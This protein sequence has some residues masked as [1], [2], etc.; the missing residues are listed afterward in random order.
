MRL[1]VASHDFYPDPGSGGTGRYVYETTRRLADRGHDVTVITR[2]RG[3]C[4]RRETVAGVRVRRYDLTIADRWGPGVLADLPGAAGAVSTFLDDADPELLSLQG[5]VTGL[6]ADRA[7]T[8]SVPRSCTFHSPWPTE[9]RLRTRGSD[10][11]WPRRLLNGT[12]RAGFEQGLLARTDEIVTLSRFMQTRLQQRYD[13]SS[14][15]AVVP[16]GVDQGT[17]DPDAGTAPAL[18]GEDPAFLTV[19]RLSPRMGHELLL[20]AFAAVRDRHPDAHLFIAGD[21]PLREDLE[22]R[23]TELGVAEATTFLGYVPDEQLPATYAT[24]DVFVLPTTALEGFGLA[25]LEALASGTPVVGTPV[26]ATPELLRGVEHHDAVSAPMVVDGA[27]PGDL[28]AGMTAWADLQRAEREAAGRACRRHTCQY[29][30]WE[31][32]V[33]GLESGYLSLVDGEASWG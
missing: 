19:R 12:I 20:E 22:E 9:Y 8:A 3:E 11:S 29:Y 13:P 14:P 33:A 21:G 6:L 4:P 1:T 24:A 27:T 30:T 10:R 28:A 16:G 25:T 2:H 17:Y 7:V 23:A 5:P 18:A 31:K 26:G 32:T 15:A